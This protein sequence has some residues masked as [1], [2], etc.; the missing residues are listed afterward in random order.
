MTTLEHDRADADARLRQPPS[1]AKWALGACALLLVVA[2]GLRFEALA[3]DALRADYGIQYHLSRLT[4]QGAVPIRDF[5]HG[6]NALSWMTGAALYRLVGGSATWWMFGWLHVTAQ[7]LA[8]LAVLGLAWRLRFRAG[9]IVVLFASWMWLTSVVN[10]KYAIPSLWL[11]ALVPVGALARTRTAVIARFALA[12]VTFWAHIDLAVMLTGGVV[13]YDLLGQRE[14]TWRDR[15]L[16]AAA[17]PTGL[18]AALG[19]QAA[20]YTR[21]GVSAVGLV[22]FLL[23]APGGTVEGT[24]FGY[25]LFRPPDF[26]TLVYPLSLLLPLVPAVWWRL[27]DPTRLA[28]LL[29]LGMSVVAIRKPDASH[30]AA[31]A[32]LLAVVAVLALRDLLTE[33]RTLTPASSRGLALPPVLLGAAWFAV[34]VAVG[35][36]WDHLLAAAGLVAVG[37]LGPLVGAGGERKGVSVGAL[38]GA[39]ALLVASVGGHIASQLPATDDDLKARRIAAEV[40]P[41][42]DDCLGDDRA[43]WVVPEPLGLYRY[44]EVRNPTP[45]YLFWGFGSETDRVLAMMEAGEIPAIIQVNQWPRGEFDRLGPEIADRYEPC[46]DVAVPET[47]D[48]VT[49][50]LHEGGAGVSGPDGTN[51]ASAAHPPTIPAGVVHNAVHP[52][53]EELVTH[54]R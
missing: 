54:V 4:A 14:L 10:G 15:L 51:D 8:G 48:H 49:V 40:R 24:N 17:G 25:P 33:R 19:I 20:V 38:A 36:A 45:F 3:A 37:M 30:L 41:H 18:L 6:W 16:R 27:S 32:T 21:L 9:W 44:L 7:L 35:F 53:L 26:R 13:L 22:E 28:A 34:A 23:F 50:W 46:A 11:L 47:G 2:V 42:V 39:A 43:A 1:S 52:M 12:A 5:E 29:H 31:A